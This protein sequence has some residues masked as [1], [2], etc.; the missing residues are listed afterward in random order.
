MPKIREFQ[1]KAMNGEGVSYDEA[2][3]LLGRNDDET[4]E[5]IAAANEI[6][7]H[8]KGNKVKLCSIVNAKSGRCPED[9]GYCAQS[10]RHKAKINIYPLMSAK[11]IHEKAKKARK[12]GASCFSIVTSGK[13][14]NSAKEMDEICLALKKIGSIN[15]NRCASLGILSSDQLK[16]LKTAGLKKFHHNLETSKSHFGKICTTHKYEDRI[17]TI[18][19]AKEAGLSVCSG[20]IFGLGESLAQRVELTFMIKELDPDSIP[21]NFLNPI[22]GTKLEKNP[23]L[24]PLE[25]LRIIAMFRFVMPEK[26]IVICGGREVTLRS[27]QPLMFSAGANMTMLGNYLTTAGN[28][29]KDDLKMIADLGLEVS[30]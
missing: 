11:E 20:G 28:K 12:E 6:R 22:K 3:W 2:K 18:K 25:A 5:I 29:P 1:N 13:G 23:I 7:R 14:I 4:I 26:D 21:I 19:A 9:C 10:S 30:R 8:F 27:L 17:A 16:K 24:E 15:L